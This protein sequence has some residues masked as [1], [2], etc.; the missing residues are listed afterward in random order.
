[1]RAA[2]AVLVDESLDGRDV[3]EPASTRPA[4]SASFRRESYRRGELA[5]LELASSA[6]HVTLRVFRAGTEHVRI[7]AE[8]V[9]EGAPVG[10]AQ[11]LGTVAAGQRVRV[12]VG[13]WPSGL[14]FARLS[15]AGAKLGFAPFVLRPTRIG[16]ERVAVVLPTQTWQAYNFRDDDHDGRPNSWYGSKIRTVRIDRPY[17]NRGVPRHYR[18]YD[19]PFL[20]W[21]I[22]TRRHVDVL[23]DGDLDGATSAVALAAAYDLIVFPGHHEYVTWREYDVIRGY[24]DLGG[25]LAFLSA[26]NFFWRVDRHRNTITRVAQWRRLGLPE[27]ALI[28]VQYIG[29][30][31]GEHRGVWIPRPRAAAV[32]WLLDGMTTRLASFGSGGIEADA[33]SPASPHGVQIVAEIPDLLGQGKTAQMTYYET[34]QGARVFAAGAFGFTGLVWQTLGSRIFANLWARLAAPG[35]QAVPA[36]AVVG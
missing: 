19:Q 8:D 36:P 16:E 25:N 1:M 27:A 6:R 2:P 28:G 30:D 29:N 13:D 3:W 20:G 4:I 9:M 35:E 26:N 5:S 11:R 22:A 24:R 15:G 23:S 31:R 33:T 10:S 14:Y 7:D 12:R 32:A 18:Q 34:P 17:E 21:L